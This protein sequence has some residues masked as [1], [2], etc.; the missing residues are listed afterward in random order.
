MKD[1]SM[2]QPVVMALPVRGEWLTPNTPG[3]KIPSHG[4]DRLGT[5][6]AYDFIQVDWNRKGW[7][8]YRRSVA[9]Y[10]IGELCLED[11]YCWGQP[12][13]APCTGKVV[14]AEDG[15][16]EQLSTNLRKDVL[17]AYKNAHSMID[18]ARL[19]AGNYVM[20]QYLPHVFAVLCHLQTGSVRVK[21]G[22]YVEQGTLLGKVGHSGNSLMPHLHF[23][24]MDRMDLTQAKGVPCVFAAYD[25]WQNGV[26]QRVKN[27][28]PKK[29]ERIR[30][31]ESKH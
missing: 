28:T 1:E 16:P 14:R 19:F 18:D 17:N 26:W 20:I 5:R 27:G 2:Q 11:Y 3:S 12:V 30:S 23:Q 15:W 8:A 25:V 4:T 24:L 13:F 7:P 22:Q 10:L 31:L 6:Y 9:R 29:T 21:V